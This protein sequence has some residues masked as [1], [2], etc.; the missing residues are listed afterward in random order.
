[1]GHLNSP[2]GKT[3]MRLLLFILL[4]SIALFTSSCNQILKVDI[5]I[6]REL[7]PYYEWLLSFPGLHPPSEAP[8]PIEILIS[9]SYGVEVSSQELVFIPFH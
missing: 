6:P 9:M 7:I 5:V 1:M 3:M 8:H 4:I 2:T